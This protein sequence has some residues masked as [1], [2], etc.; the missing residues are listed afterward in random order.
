MPDKELRLAWKTKNETD[1]EPT[2]VV[3]ATKDH[4]NTLCGH[5]LTNKGNWYLWITG[6]GHHVNCKNCLRI[7]K[8]E[9]V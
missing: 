1:S 7:M 9:K 6:N 2:N 8:N 4:E 5:E 3:H